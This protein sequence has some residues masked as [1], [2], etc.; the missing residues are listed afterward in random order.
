MVSYKTFFKDKINRR[1]KN[2]YE[3]NVKAKERDFFEYYNNT[4]NREECY[5]DDVLTDAVF[6]DHS[7]SNNKDLSDDKYIIVPKETKIG[8]GSYVNWRRQ[9]W[10][11][12][13][14]EFKTIATHQQLKIKIVNDNIKWLI[15]KD[16]K[17]VCNNGN[18]WGAYVQNQTLY[19]LGIARQGNHLDLVNSKMMLY[20]QNN[21]ETRNLK[22][23]DRIFVGFTV[24]KVMFRDGVSRKG[25]I[26]FLLE[27]D[28]IKSTD[29]KELMIADYYP[30]EAPKEEDNSPEA[31]PEIKGNSQGRISKTYTY[32]IED[33]Y[34]VDEWIL[35]TADVDCLEVSE[36]TN[37]DIKIRIKDDSRNIGTIVNLM[38][39]V[40][41]NISMFTIRI[42]SKF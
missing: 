2:A 34:T 15:D 10:L 28:T 5:I 7:Q 25:L 42:S 31:I 33:G 24:Y 14:E 39:K 30:D 17:T 21:E 35:D 22:T 41:S 16:K 38:A 29:N 20:M 11:V 1:G 37:T 9:P 6:Q 3:R 23:N 40:G 19:T 36:E 4:L 13:T 8:I 18:G 27:E 12:F 26:N 32:T